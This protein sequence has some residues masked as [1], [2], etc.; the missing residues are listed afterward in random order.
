MKY[1]TD[2]DKVINRAVK[3]RENKEAV[4][5]AYI[6]NIV[7]LWER[8]VER[9]IFIELGSDQTSLH[10]PWSGGYYPN[11]IS[12]EEANK[13]LVNDVEK[14]KIEVRKTLVKH[15]NAINKLSSKGMMFLIMEMPFY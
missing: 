3:A 4:S 6:G 5:L 14:F 11:T 15:T 10:N 12:F 2:L 9:D 13:L 7:D 1:I 8:I